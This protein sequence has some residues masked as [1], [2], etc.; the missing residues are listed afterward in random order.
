V[1]PPSSDIEL[2][3]DRNVYEDLR[4]DRRQTLVG[5]EDDMWAEFAD[6]A[7][8]V[9]ALPSTVDPAF[10]SLSLEAGGRAEPVAQAS[11][12]AH[13]GLVVGADHRD[14]GLG[15]AL[16]CSLVDLCRDRELIPPCSTQ[17]DNG[18]A[19][20]VIRRAGFRS[21]HRVFRVDLGT[22]E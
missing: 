6:Q 13:L 8:V 7:G 21:R 10:L 11:D 15:T 22:R 14:H 4:A 2:T 16:M 3:A 5:L 17:P 1:S 9:A 18:A 12:H 19:L 20:R